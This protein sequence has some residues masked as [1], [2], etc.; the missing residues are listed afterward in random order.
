MLV[1]PKEQTTNKPPI[2][3]RH[4]ENK[5]EQVSIGMT[6]SGNPEDDLARVYFSG[7]HSSFK[8][9]CDIGFTD[10]SVEGKDKCGKDF[11]AHQVLTWSFL[12]IQ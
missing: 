6:S 7:T 11:A 4:V 2:I 3:R 1:Q 9:G 5:S 12:D 8:V 10:L